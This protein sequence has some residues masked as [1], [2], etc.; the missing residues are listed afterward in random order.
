VLTAVHR[1]RPIRIPDG[2]QGLGANIYVPGIVT[3][4]W[5]N[6][7]AGEMTSHCVQTGLSQE[8]K[9]TP[10]GI[11][12]GECIQSPH[13]LD[14]Q[15]IFHIYLPPN[16]Q[17]RMADAGVTVP[18]APL[19]WNIESGGEHLIV[20]P[21]M[22][23]DVTFLTVTVD[24]TGYAEQ[25]YGARIVAGWVQPSPENWGLERWKIGIPAINILNDHDSF[26]YDDGDW[27]FWTAINNRDQEWTRLLDGD[28]V[29]GLH[30]FT[31][32]F[33][34]ESPQA[35]RS[36]GPHVQLFHPRYVD[37]PGSPIEDL[38]RS[39]FL[40]SSGYD[41]E[42][43]DDPTGV[44][45]HLLYL[46]SWSTPIGSR[47]NLSMIS[48]TGDY[49][50]QYFVERL[51]PVLPNLTAAGQALASTYSLHPK[52]ARCSRLPNGTCVLFPERFVVA[53]P[54]HPLLAR[55]GPKTPEIDWQDFPAYEP[56]EPEEL[57]FTGISF[58]ELRASLERTR[59]VDPK[60]V[61]QFAVEL[62]QQFDQVRGTRME[63]EHAKALPLLKANLPADLWRRYFVDIE[64]TTAASS[65]LWL[66]TAVGAFAAFLA[67]LVSWF[68]RRIKLH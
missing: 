59:R 28:A 17:K 40:H 52:E 26:P 20:A 35:N 34:T 53:M 60:R 68:L 23:G 67:A 7:R 64:P 10:T 18:P 63:A 21:S 39:F 44:V 22:W 51:G 42:T 50:L 36:L 4:I 25:E 61:E 1:R 9:V 45:N 38:N 8:A 24:L 41:A 48:N 3:D 33:E 12:W 66:W 57:G 16:P 13:P 49:F 31:P 46:G 56:Q 47:Q 54:W 2:W 27:V 5:A 30:A 11:Q 37:F 29:T 58:A 62:R 6:K 15:F 55:L 19:Y 14:Q 32:P 65:K 43:W